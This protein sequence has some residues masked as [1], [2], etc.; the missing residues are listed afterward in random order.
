MTI[1]MSITQRLHLFVA[2]TDEL[3]ID[4]YQCAGRYFFI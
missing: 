4:G 2:Q 1:T 3:S